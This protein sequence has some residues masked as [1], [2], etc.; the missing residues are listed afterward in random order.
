MRFKPCL[1][2]QYCLENSTTLH[3][4]RCCLL[5]S[6]MHSVLLCIMA[7]WGCRIVVVLSNLLI[8][9]TSYIIYIVFLFVYLIISL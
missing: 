3:H 4:G 7:S 8:I 5:E 2:L 9:T 1:L 6:F